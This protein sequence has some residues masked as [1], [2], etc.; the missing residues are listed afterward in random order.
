MKTVKIT[1]IN[2]ALFEKNDACHFS[3]AQN[4]IDKLNNLDVKKLTKI[5]KGIDKNFNALRNFV[6]R[7]RA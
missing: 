6:W 5:Q 2:I 1:L 4:R 7:Y 3:A